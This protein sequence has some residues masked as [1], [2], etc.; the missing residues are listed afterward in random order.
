MRDHQAAGPT[1][2]GRQTHGM[3]G[4]PNGPWGPY[5]Y[6]PG[7][8][9][10]EPELINRLTGRHWHAEDTFLVPHPLTRTSYRLTD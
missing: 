4:F 1:L 8:L 7:P 10:D 3:A 2:P 5:C 9:D 6:G